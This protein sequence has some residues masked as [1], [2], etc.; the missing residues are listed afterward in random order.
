MAGGSVTGT[1]VFEVNKT[2]KTLS[3]LYS[4]DY[5]D[6]EDTAEIRLKFE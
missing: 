2:D 6:F 4:D 5:T 1:V 3:L